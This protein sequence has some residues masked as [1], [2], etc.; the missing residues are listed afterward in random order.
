[1]QLT[2]TS[3]ATRNL[4]MHRSSIGVW[5]SARQNLPQD[6]YLD[7]PDDMT[8]PAYAR[9]LFDPLCHVR[10]FLFLKVQC[11]ITILSTVLC[12]GKG[13]APA[14]GFTSQ[15]LQ[16]VFARLVRY[17]SFSFLLISC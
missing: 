9:L 14:L 5:K 16:E 13:Q 11:L 15:V 2:R 6:L 4:L 17:L 8:E 7:I 10:S 12:Q 1:M 3:K